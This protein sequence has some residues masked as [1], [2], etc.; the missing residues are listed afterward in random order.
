MKKQLILLFFMAATLSLRAQGIEFF[1][2]TWAEALEEAK[3]QD[4]PIFVDAYAVWCGPC[5]RMSAEVFPDEAVGDYYN[6]NFISMKIDMEKG[7]GLTFGQK[8]PVRAYP[9]L[10][11]IDHTGEIIMQ[12][13]G[14]QGTEQFIEL[15]KKAL[16]KIDRSVSYA[17]EYDKGSRDPKLMYN[18][19]KALNKAGKPSM[20]IVNDYLR[21]QKDLTTEDNL[22][23][24][25][26]AAN[27][28]DSKAF[29][30]LIQYKAKIVALTSEKA[31]QEQI[32][33]ACKNSAKKAVEFQSRELLTETQTKARQHCPAEAGAFA[34]Q[35]EMDYAL[36]TRD[37][38]NYLVACKEFIKKEAKDRPAEYDKQAK[39]L[40]NNFRDDVKAAKQAQE[41][42]REAAQ[43]GKTY[44]YYYSYASILF[45]NGEK[46]DAKKA[47]EK[48][49][50][51][52]KEKGPGAIRNVEMLLQRIEG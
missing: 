13:T 22:R 8:Y 18:Y 39:I 49:M 16:N 30:L 37:L 43:E 27:E 7:D 23:F 25:M 28:A 50:D 41:F 19:V 29:D 35:S 24:I 20:K 11:Y 2:G 1:H 52:A 15:G 46:E 6:K 47:A 38:K 14:A 12:V 5:K 17:A 32:M 34:L 42:A 3:K 51:L 4:R 44:E 21:T 31:V 45:N 36:A 40:M 9:T 10:F 26:V 33:Q 48:A